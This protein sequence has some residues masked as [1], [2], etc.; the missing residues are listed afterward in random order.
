MNFNL[1]PV[2]KNLLIINVLVFFAQKSIGEPDEFLIENLFALH[3]FGKGFEPYQLF[4]YSFLHS[5]YDLNHLIFFP[6]LLL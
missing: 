3:Q 1:T 2:V 4:T 5:P 6:H